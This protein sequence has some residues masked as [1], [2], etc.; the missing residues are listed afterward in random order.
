M[1]R[2]IAAAAASMALAGGA[3]WSAEAALHEVRDPHYGDALFH[4]YQDHYFSALTALMVSQHFGRVSH[5]ADKAEVLRGGMLLSYGMHLEA[6]EIFTR[7]IERGAE[8]AVR[9]RAWFY[10]AKIRYQ[11][12]LPAQAEEAIG[13]IGGRLPDELEEDRV[14]LAANLHMARGDYAGAAAVLDAA[15]GAGLYGRY[16]LGV[17]LI[18]NGDVVHGA[19]LLDGIGRQPAATE[20]S[21]S[22][23]DKANLALGFAALQEDRAD[24]ARQYLERVRLTGLQANKAL[25]GFGWAA[26]ALKQPQQALVPWTEL[27]GRDASDPAVLEAK[28]AVPY[29]FAE[30]GARG[31]ALERYQD[32]I[33]TYERESEVLDRSIAAVQSGQFVDGLLERNPGAEMGWFWS[34]RELPDMPHSAHLSQV[35]AQ[36]EFQEAFKNYRDLQFLTRNLQTWRDNIATFDDML[37]NRRR[38]Y[39]ERLPQVRERSRD[40]GID[41]LQQRRDVL[42]DELRAAETQPDPQALADDRE[43]LLLGRLARVRATLESAAGPRAEL[44]T[45]RERYRLAAGALGWELAQEFPGRLWE[46]K[47]ALRLTDGELADARRRDAALAAAQRDEPARF[48]GFAA[49]LSDLDRRLEALIPRVQA[50]AEQQ[51]QAVQ[52]I[53]IAEL[54]RQKELLAGYSTQARFAVAQLP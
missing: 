25:L 9:D 45:A 42:A 47:K 29:A 12:G 21:R 53:A 49:R 13:R 34:L 15:G 2:W 28:L 14:L 23:R 20:E 3:A 17:A 10:L 36:H 16:N 44:A 8:P 50:L 51:R 32:A 35:M 7:L 48:D 52:D 40:L 18:K 31:Q 11:R 27:T 22:L 4:F 6:G 37:A 33:L 43:R 30:L 19:E 1:R 5:H 46:A 41:G 24:A 38:A 39:A 54:A 26:A